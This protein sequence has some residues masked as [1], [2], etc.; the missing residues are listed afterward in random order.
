MA[1]ELDTFILNALIMSF[2]VVAILNGQRLYWVFVGIGGAVLGLILA[3]WLIPNQPEWVQI[4]A[5][6]I[7]GVLSVLL[8]RMNKP[9]AVRAA[10]FV[11][12]GF[13]L[14]FLL[15]DAGLTTSSITSEVIIVVIGGIIG[16]GLEIYYGASAMIVISS[17]CGA[18]LVTVPLEASVAFQAALFSGLAAVG[19]LLQSREWIGTGDD[20][21]TV[22][23]AGIEEAIADS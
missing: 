23:T 2:G 13:I 14:N 22:G 5:V 3:D 18:A 17:F 9:I 8:A 21:D 7:F 19:M 6:L 1:F 15:T 16:V 10:A 4:L 11:L 12:G 20:P